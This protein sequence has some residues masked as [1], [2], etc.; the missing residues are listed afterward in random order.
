MSATTVSVVW[1]PPLS[2]NGIILNYTIDMVPQIRKSP[3][4]IES[5]SADTNETVEGL[6]PATTYQVAIA[7]VTSAGIG[8]AATLIVTTLPCEWQY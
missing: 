8:K 7:G 3:S 5:V 1:E 2:P 4:Y 6:E